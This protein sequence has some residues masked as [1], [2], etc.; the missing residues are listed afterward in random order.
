MGGVARR[1]FLIGAGAMLAA[2]P[3]SLRA[4]AR[5]PYRIGVLPDHRGPYYTWLLEGLHRH[6]WVEQRDFVFVQSGFTAGMDINEAARRIV[7]AQPDVIFTVVTYYVVAAQRLTATIP[8]VAWSTGYPVEAGFA[9]SLSRPAK[10][11]TGNTQ[12][13]G[14]AIWGKLIELLHEVRPEAKR[15][16]ILMS[17][18][19]PYHPK[20]ESDVVYE[21]MRQSASRAGLAA[22][23]TPMVESSQLETAL[24][25]LARA[26]PDVVILTTGL[27]VWPVREKVLAFA[28]A[29][30]WP[31]ITDSHWHPDDT[32]KPMM[33]YSPTNRLLIHDAAEYVVRILRDGVHPGDLPFRLPARFELSIN[34]RTAKALGVEIPAQLLLRADRV[35]Q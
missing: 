32:L 8:I 27:S 33:S 5:P 28:L 13:A 15:V 23:F 29:R 10:N 35:I 14:A 1:R 21:D 30:A 16:G 7:A 34:L 4:Q 31:T 12:Y 17:Y 18:L 2:A 19:P 25:D 22:H 3:A 6:G 9:E 20:A 24:A 26:A 11:I